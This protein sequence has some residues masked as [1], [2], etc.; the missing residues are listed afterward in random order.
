MFYPL[1]FRSKVDEV[2]LIVFPLLFLVFNLIY[3]P[4][5]VQSANK[6]EMQSEHY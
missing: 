5:C 2:F 1:S 6:N 4:L 3:W